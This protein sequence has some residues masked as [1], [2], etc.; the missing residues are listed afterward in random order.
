MLSPLNPELLRLAEERD[1]VVILDRPG[2]LLVLQYGYDEWFMENR[3]ASF[4]VLR[5]GERDTTP[6]VK[7]EATR[8]IDAEKY[9]AAR[10]LGGWRDY[11]LRLPVF[12]ALDQLKYPKPGSHVEPTPE[13]PWASKAVVWADGALKASFQLGSYANEFTYYQDASF[14]QMRAAYSNRDGAPL[15]PAPST[16]EP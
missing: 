9:L 10:L 4:A 13:S 5:L 12:T 16:L 2:Y 14:E 8:L 1:R 3:G 7:M 15:F 6:T 11:K